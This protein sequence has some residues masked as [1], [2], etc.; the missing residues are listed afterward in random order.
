[1]SLSRPGIRASTA[2]VYAPWAL[3]QAWVFGAAHVFEP[4][5]IIGHFLAK[6]RVDYGPFGRFGQGG[7]LGAGRQTDEEK[8]N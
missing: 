1:M 2:S 4:A 3:N 6:I 7:H 5:V 8:C